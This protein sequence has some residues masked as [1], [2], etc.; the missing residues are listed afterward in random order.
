MA[1]QDGCDDRGPIDPAHLLKR[2][3]LGIG[4]GAVVRL[5][6]SLQV[7]QDKD[8]KQIRA[9][10]YLRRPRTRASSSSL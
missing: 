2:G 6:D 5:M 10:R 4:L 7:E 8:G 1:L 3:G 9:V